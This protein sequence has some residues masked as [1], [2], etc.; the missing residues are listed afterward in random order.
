MQQERTINELILH[1]IFK[2][3]IK[4]KELDE[5]KLKHKIRMKINRVINS[6]DDLLEKYN[7]FP[8]K[9]IA[10]TKA[11][12]LPH[13]FCLEIEKR[14][15]KYLLAFSEIDINDYNLTKNVMENKND[16]SFVFDLLI[17][18]NV[19]IPTDDILLSKGQIDHQFKLNLFLEHLFYDKFEFN[20][21]DYIT[22]VIAYQRF[23]EDDNY[24]EHNEYDYAVYDVVKAVTKLRNPHKY[25]FSR[26]KNK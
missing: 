26:K 20:E 10:K 12:I 23:L 14:I 8:E 2:Y 15:L 16:N 22:D 24:F 18:N 21:Y 1:L 6:D 25:Y 4:I 11:K 9:P 3:K 13:E 17:K 5:K 19:K 7:K